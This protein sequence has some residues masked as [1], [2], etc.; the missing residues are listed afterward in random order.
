MDATESPAPTGAPIPVVT[1]ESGEETQPEIPRPET[2]E[3]TPGAENTWDRAPTSTL[4]PKDGPK[5]SVPLTAPAVELPKQ[6][7][8]EP[9][10]DPPPVPPRNILPKTNGASQPQAPSSRRKIVVAK[11]LSD[12]INTY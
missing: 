1:P 7:P 2:V 6:L 3:R 10:D 12:Y 5:T 8:Q 4:R 11:R 9:L